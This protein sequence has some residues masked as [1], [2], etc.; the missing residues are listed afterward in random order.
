[1]DRLGGL[2]CS[3]YGDN[4]ALVLQR[5]ALHLLLSAAGLL[6]PTV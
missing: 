2:A 4:G 6:V 5:A 1:M 3:L